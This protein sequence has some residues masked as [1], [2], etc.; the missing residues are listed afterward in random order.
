MESSEQK[1]NRTFS[2]KLAMI[3]GVVSTMSERETHLIH[4]R[5]SFLG[6]Y[7]YSTD[8]PHVPFERTCLTSPCSLMPHHVS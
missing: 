7:S 8:S 2:S 1:R 3:E 4:R 6:V 5:L